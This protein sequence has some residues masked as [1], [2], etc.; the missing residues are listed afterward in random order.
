M[1]RRKKTNKFIVVSIL[2]L[3][4]AILGIAGIHMYAP[5]DGIIREVL[6]PVCLALAAVAVVLWVMGYV[7]RSREN[8]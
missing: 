4:V 1:T 6:R 7:K 2:L 5:G 3:A 8:D